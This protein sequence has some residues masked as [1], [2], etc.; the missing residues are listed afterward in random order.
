[1]VD[2]LDDLFERAARADEPPDLN[3]IRKHSL[4]LES[5]GVDRPAARI[6]SN[7]AGDYGS[8][9]NERIGNGDW[10]TE[11]ELGQTWQ[12]RFLSMAA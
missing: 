2:L 3:F 7:P 4:K 5:Q 12:V 11:S 10:E 9:V 8:L 1:V 6:F